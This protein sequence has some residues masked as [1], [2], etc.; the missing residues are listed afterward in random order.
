MVRA[1]TENPETVLKE[2]S[3]LKFI[4][5][6]LRVNERLSFSVGYPYSLML[7]KLQDNL[8]KLYLYFSQQINAEIA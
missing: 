4:T 7:L 1:E 3:A 6:F 2:D 8:I 5:Y